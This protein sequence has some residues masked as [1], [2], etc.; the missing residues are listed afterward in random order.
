MSIELKRL[1]PLCEK[2]QQLYVEF[3]S[4]SESLN[5]KNF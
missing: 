4:I 5:S 2:V 3:T 1:D